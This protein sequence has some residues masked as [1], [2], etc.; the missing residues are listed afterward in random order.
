MCCGFSNTYRLFGVTIPGAF[1]PWGILVIVHLLFSKMM[2]FLNISGILIGIS[3]SYIAL[4][5]LMQNLSFWNLT[6]RRTRKFG[7]IDSKRRLFCWTRSVEVSHFLDR[8]P[9]LRLR[10]WT[11][12][13]RLIT[14]RLPIVRVQPN[15]RIHKTT[16]CS[17]ILTLNFIQWVP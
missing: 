5:S 9:F 4:F 2:L 14:W 13:S 15:V 8:N 16:R 12:C 11:N 6:L 10:A 1:W 3:C 7:R 17:I